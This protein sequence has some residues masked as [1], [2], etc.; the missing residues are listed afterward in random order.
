MRKVR[1][2]KG[3]EGKNTRG[4]RMKGGVQKHWR[5][6][7]SHSHSGG[8]P[9]VPCFFP[10]RPLVCHHLQ[11]SFHLFGMWLRGQHFRN[12]K[13]VHMRSMSACEQLVGFFWRHLYANLHKPGSPRRR[14]NKLRREQRRAADF[15][16]QVSPA[17]TGGGVY[18]QAA[19][20]ADRAHAWNYVSVYLI[21]LRAPPGR[22]CRATVMNKHY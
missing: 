18:K 9:E 19:R 10:P 12:I 1:A 21:S 5:Q 15:T 14:G 11:R 6:N 8:R 13:A 2:V 3:K 16:R 22:H 20:S 17:C 4:T 7:G